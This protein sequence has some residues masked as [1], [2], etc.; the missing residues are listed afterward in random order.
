MAI[1]GYDEDQITDLISRHFTPSKEISSVE[2]LKGRESELLTIRRALPS[3]GR[4]VFIFGDRGVGKTSLAVTSAF[5][6]NDSSSLPIYVLCGEGMTFFEV[7]QAIANATVPLDERIKNQKQSGALNLKLP[8]ALGG[9]GVGGKFSNESAT[10]LPRPGNIN[11]ALDVLRYVA[12]KRTGRTVII[13]DEF[14][15]I[16]DKTQK[17]LF[18][19]FIK[20]VPTLSDDVKL[21]M[22]GIGQNVDD[23]LGAHP[24]AGRYFEPVPV[25]KLHHD[26][27]WS[28][29]TDA[30]DEAGIKIPELMLRRIGIVSDQF[31]HFVHLLG[32][33][34]FWAIFDDPEEVTTAKPEHYRTALKGALKKTER[35]LALAYQKATEKSK[36]KQDYEEALWAIADTSETRRQLKQIHS[37]SYLPLKDRLQ[38]GKPLT[39]EQLNQ[40]LHNLRDERHGEVLINHKSGWFSFRENVFRGYVRLVAEDRGVQLKIEPV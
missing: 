21:I 22:C 16:R 34:L 19:E 28:I 9:F 26:D 17:N 18:A 36:N 40:R 12:S 1:R 6:H 7:I 32:D 14:D 4:H 11:E 2:K 20:N 3:Q 5:L 37:G 10:E 25:Q 31:P 39:R 33:C 8:D 30:A 13:I 38:N 15:R 23:I 35:D 27:L 29:I 24:S